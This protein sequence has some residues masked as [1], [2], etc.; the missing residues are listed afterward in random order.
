MAKTPERAPPLVY[1]T[2]V[3]RICPGCRRPAAECVCRTG[4]GQPAGERAGGSVRVGRQTQGRAGKGVTVISGLPLT[5][6][7]LA[8]LA[9]EL[10]RRCGS[11]GTVRDGSIE[12]QGEHR[13]VLVE[14]LTRRGFAARRSGG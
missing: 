1:S 14:E 11:G 13:D 10:K 2:G 6:A 9:T 3:G 7:E 8:Q 12:I 4:S 5:A